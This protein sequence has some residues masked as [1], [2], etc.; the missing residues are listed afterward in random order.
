MKRSSLI[1]LLLLSTLPLLAKLPEDLT[2]PEFRL[3]P[4]NIGADWQKLL[5]ELQA[6]PP[7]RAEFEERRFFPFRRDYTALTGEIRLDPDHGLSLHYITPQDQLMVV[8]ARGGFLQNER[9]RRRELPDNPNARAATGAL[10][11]VLRFDLP[12]LAQDFDIY[13]ARDENTWAFTFVPRADGKLA[14]ALSPVTVQGEGARVQLIEMRKSDRQRV[15][16]H[17]GQTETNV[18]FTDE[19]L[20]RYFR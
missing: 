18:V 9:G 13:A 8:D 20:S 11:H 6:A 2:Q 15:E 5:T 16:I 19:E 17:V 12:R 14:K 1:T 7:L 4:E 10:L 3:Q